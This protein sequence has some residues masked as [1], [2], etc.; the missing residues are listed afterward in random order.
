MPVVPIPW[1]EETEAA[2]LADADAGVSWIP[3]DLWSRG[4]CGLKLLQYGASGLPAIANPVGVHPEI[5]VPGV[6][7][8]LA[9]TQEDW[10]A[11]VKA[12]ADD[13]ENRC[14]MGQRARALVE[15]GYSVRAWEGSFVAAISGAGQLQTHSPHL[16]VSRPGDGWPVESRSGTGQAEEIE[17]RGGAS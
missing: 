8:H 1:S 12:L 13:P 14:R 11:A 9:E 16:T 2:E 4:T 6:N 3:D 10:V 7:G 15:S 17:T 5:I